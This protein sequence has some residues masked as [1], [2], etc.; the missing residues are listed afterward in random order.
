MHPRLRDGL[1]DKKNWIWI[2]RDCDNIHDKDIESLMRKKYDK[3]GDKLLLDLSTKVV[4]IK[5]DD[6][7]I[8]KAMESS[9]FLVNRILSDVEKL[10]YVDKIQYIDIENNGLL[11]YINSYSEI[12]HVI[13]K[14]D[15]GDIILPINQNYQ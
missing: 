9:F 6:N 1:K 2:D 5:D 10:K 13:Y 11:H 15:D 14:R 7:I 4:K 3:Q 12:M 8:L